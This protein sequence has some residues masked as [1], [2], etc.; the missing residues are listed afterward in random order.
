MTEGREE[1]G[2]AGRAIRTEPNSGRP[3]GFTVRAGAAQALLGDWQVS[4][5]RRPSNRK[6]AADTA[7]FVQD[8]VCIRLRESHLEG[9]FEAWP[10]AAVRAE[11][12]TP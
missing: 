1:K 2:T 10:L 8:G 6:A 9:A 5:S 7:P 3:A 4:R 11:E 12:G